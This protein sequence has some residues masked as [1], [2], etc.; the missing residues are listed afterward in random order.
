M[1]DYNDC[2]WGEI[3]SIEQ[4]CYGKGE[5]MVEWVEGILMKCVG[6]LEDVVGLVVFFVFDD[7]C[8]FIGQIINIDG[9]L[10]ML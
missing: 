5:L 9:G 3:F 6:K 7:V 8:Y 10:I 2:V 4:K 1:W